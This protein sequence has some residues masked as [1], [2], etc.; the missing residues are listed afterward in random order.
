MHIHKT[1]THARTHTDIRGFSRLT[2]KEITSSFEIIQDTTD[3]KG[4][5]FLAIPDLTFLLEKKNPFRKIKV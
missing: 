2:L 1:P 3:H 4:K 5:N